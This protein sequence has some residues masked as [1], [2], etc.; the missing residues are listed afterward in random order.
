MAD[1]TYILSKKFYLLSVKSASFTYFP[2][3]GLSTG[4]H[5]F[6]YT[7]NFYSQ[8]PKRAIKHGQKGVLMFSSAVTSKS[9]QVIYFNLS[10]SQLRGTSHRF[11]TRN[12]IKIKMNVVEFTIIRCINPKQCKLFT[13]KIL[14]QRRAAPPGARLAP[15][16]FI[17]PT[18]SNYRSQNAGV[19]KN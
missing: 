7:S 4:F 17:Y 19:E 1:S 14:Q 13:M 8:F 11:Q 12:E 16:K 15:V 6:L 5:L 10:N 9:S 18:L 3:K 2:S